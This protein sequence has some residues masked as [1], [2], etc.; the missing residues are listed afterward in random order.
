MAAL[1]AQPA[2]RIVEFDP[3]SYA[4]LALIDAQVL[5]LCMMPP[6]P[7]PSA[8]ARSILH[9]PL[10]VLGLISAVHSLALP[11]SCGIYCF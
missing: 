3:A 5:V 11:K 10:H 8:P 2:I 9:H 7:P 4:T 6:P 1:R